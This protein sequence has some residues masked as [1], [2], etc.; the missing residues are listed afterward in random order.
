MAHAYAMSLLYRN[1]NADVNVNGRV[2]SLLQQEGKGGWV[3]RRLDVSCE[4]THY[5]LILRGDNHTTPPPRATSLPCAEP[6]PCKPQTS[7]RADKVRGRCVPAQL[8]FNAATGTRI[9]CMYLHFSSPG[10][11]GAFGSTIPYA[12]IMHL[13]PLIYLTVPV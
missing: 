2:G 1:E 3:H 7:C 6:Q 10:S 11:K 12:E 9:V 4:R 13:L 5:Y 8:Q